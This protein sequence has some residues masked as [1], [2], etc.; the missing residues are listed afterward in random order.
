M[1]VVVERMLL[2]SNVSGFHAIRRE[3]ERQIC[4]CTSIFSGKPKD[5]EELKAED[6]AD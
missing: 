4:Q 2:K 5:D 1:Q 3:N 6:L